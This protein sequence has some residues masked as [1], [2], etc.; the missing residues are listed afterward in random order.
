MSKLRIM[1]NTD[2]FKCPICDSKMDLVDQKSLICLN[3]HCF[4]ISRSGYVNFLTKPVKTDYDKAMFHS[5]N[6][7][8][9]YG[10]F[11]PMI[12]TITDIISNTIQITGS[13][14]SVIIDVGCGEGSH[15]HQIV[16][17]L[18]VK[19]QQEFEGLGMDIS[20]EGIQMATRQYL[21][22]VWCVG[23]LTSSPFKDRKFDVILN[24][25]SP[26]NYAEFNRL[27]TDTGILIKV[28][29]G[30]N[31]LRELRDVLYN[32]ADKQSY[33]NEKVQKHFCDNF[34]LIDSRQV[35]YH[36]TL[37]AEML[38]YLI[39]MTPLSW[40]ATEQEINQAIDSIKGSITADFSILY[41]RKRG[42]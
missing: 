23:D 20:K 26:S 4:D 39:R 35:H 37:N 38:A 30:K 21:D 41:G 15:L 32:K 5:R 11:D 10:F 29:P 33:S 40:N 14:R 19:T 22:C 1:K 17:E 13:R 2:L 8:C 9:K 3:N 25:L 36:K 7:I 27:L 28:V 34:N 31:Y 18:R 12:D 42:N 6:I 24:V 16:N